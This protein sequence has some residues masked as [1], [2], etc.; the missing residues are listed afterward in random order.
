MKNNESSYRK[1]IADP[2]WI[3]RLKDTARDGSVAELRK[4]EKEL[5]AA[6]GRLEGYLSGQHAKLDAESVRA[7]VRANPDVL[8][9]PQRR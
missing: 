1:D 9:G 3:R 7:W 2:L 8:R 5:S 4:L 6:I